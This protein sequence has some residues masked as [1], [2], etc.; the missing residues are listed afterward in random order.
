MAT[1]ALHLR[2]RGTATI[3]LSSAALLLAACSG[4]SGNER[5]DTTTVTAPKE[6][7]LVFSRGGEQA[8]IYTT[9]LDGN[10]SRL[11]STYAFEFAPTFSPD[12]SRIF[13][14]GGQNSQISVMNTDGTEPTELTHMDAGIGRPKVSRDGRKIVFYAKEHRNLDLYTMSSDGSD[15]TQLTHSP[16]FDADADWSP[17]GERIVYASGRGRNHDLY[18]VHP[19]GTGI[20]RLTSAKSNEGFP[21]WSPDGEKIAFVSNRDGNDEIY[22]MNADGTEGKRLT[23]SP[24]WDSSPAWSLDGSAIAF[25]S[26]RDGDGEIYVMSADGSLVR[27]VTRN[28]VDDDFPDWSPGELPARLLAATPEDDCVEHWN[29]PWFDGVRPAMMG[30]AGAAGP[31]EKVSVGFM[32][33]GECRITLLARPGHPFQMIES[34]ENEWRIAGPAEIETGPWNAS[35]DGA[36]FVTLDAGFQG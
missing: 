22:L 23:R 20:A 26:G 2:F 8:D 6:V 36:G 4:G 1:K 16:G 32:P 35:A 30:F 11:T 27:R 17:D 33:G 7:R 25:S 24:W 21:V 10:E 19:D 34:A 12:G 9:S 15:L 29:A 5:A 31:I 3:V 14:S 28:A 13:F 18:V